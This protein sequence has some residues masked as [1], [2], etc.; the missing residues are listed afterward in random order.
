MWGWPRTSKKTSRHW[1]SCVSLPSGYLSGHC[2]VSTLQVIRCH[3]VRVHHCFTV[4]FGSNKPGPIRRSVLLH[5]V[6]TDCDDQASLCST[7]LHLVSWPGLGLHVPLGQ[8]IAV[9]SPYKWWYCRSS[10]HFCCLHQD[11]P[12]FASS[13][14]SPPS[15]RPSAATGG[16]HAEHGE[17]QE[18]SVRHV[19]G[20]RTFPNLLPPFLVS[21]SSQISNRKGRP[22]WDL[23][24]LQLLACITEFFIEPVRVLLEAAWSPHR[25]REKVAQ[26]VLSMKLRSVK[27]DKDWNWAYSLSCYSTK[28]KGWWGQTGLCITELSNRPFAVRGRTVNLAWHRNQI[29]NVSMQVIPCVRTVCPVARLSVTASP[30]RELQDSLYTRCQFSASVCACSVFYIYSWD[31]CQWPPSQASTEKNSNK[32]KSVWQIYEYSILCKMQAICPWLWPCVWNVWGL[33]TTRKDFRT[34]II[35]KSK[36]LRIQLSAA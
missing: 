21:G 7:R 35:D 32:G 6:S 9:Y 27:E 13:A 30:L 24:G 14:D 31:D 19:N 33:L 5:Q 4:V 16:K 26:T 2:P 20:L 15:S 22:K 3:W 1:L 10:R 28:V 25:S 17:I 18:N 12:P 36:I 29:F 11:L 8:W 34:Q 23:V